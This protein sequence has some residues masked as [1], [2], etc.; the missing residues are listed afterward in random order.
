MNPNPPANLPKEVTTLGEPIA[1]FEAGT[2]QFI[3]IWIVGICGILLGIVLVGLILF[4]VAVR[5]HGSTGAPD[6]ALLGGGVFLVFAGVATLRRTSKTSGVRAIVYREGLTRLQGEK[7]DV[8]RWDEISEVRRGVNSVGTIN[9]FTIRTPM[10]LRLVCRDG[11]EMEFNETVAGLRELRQLVEE[12][13]LPLLLEPA[14]DAYKGGATL[15]FDAVIVSRDGLQYFQKTL[16]WD[17]FDR[18]EV[19]GT[20]LIIKTTDGQKL[21]FQIPFINVSNVHV[22]L[23][24]LEHIRGQR[25]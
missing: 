12:R 14:V 25:V 9:G 23:P 7:F 6:L 8:A 4:L 24:L 22:L 16:P 3:I 18:A 2:L 15:R 11:R 10:R 21:F 17:R 13:T 5:G 1:A 20:L 19:R